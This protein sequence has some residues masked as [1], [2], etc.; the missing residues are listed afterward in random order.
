MFSIR[1][2]VR[3][4]VP[5]LYAMIRELAEF[6]RGLDRLTNTEADLARDGFGPQPKFLALLLLW[7]DTVA[8]YALCFD[9]YSTWRG[10]L[11]YLEDLYVKREHRGKGIGKAA[12]ARIARLACEGNYA[13]MRWEVLD[14]N[15]PAVELYKLLGGTFLNDWRTVL[16][17][18]ASLNA[19]ACKAD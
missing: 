18:G 9:F 6:E 7:N 17:E 19:L 10:R 2:A 13:A 4:D 3:E 11:L 8:G 16:L 1:Q 14:W 15:T 12:L 5:S